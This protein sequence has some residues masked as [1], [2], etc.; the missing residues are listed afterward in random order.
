MLATHGKIVIA[1]LSRAIGCLLGPSDSLFLTEHSLLQTGIWPITQ[2][3][4]I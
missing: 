3:Y 4:E 1:A 2:A